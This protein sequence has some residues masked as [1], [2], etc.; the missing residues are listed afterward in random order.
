MSFALDCGPEEPPLE[1]TLCTHQSK[2]EFDGQSRLLTYLQDNCP[3]WQQDP[4]NRYTVNYVLAMLFSVIKHHGF[5]DRKMIYHVRGDS[6]LFR[7]LG[8]N[9][10]F[11]PEAR[12]LVK[13]HLRCNEHVLS[14]E[15]SVPFHCVPHS[16]ETII[17][18][19][20]DQVD[21]NRLFL[22]ICYQSEEA[23]T[24]HINYLLENWSKYYY[25]Y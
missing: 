7:A 13:T 25:V 18:L 20:S 6:S 10:F 9:S 5:F 17:K 14:N 8:R 11:I 22:D 3:A 23:T 4:R 24:R 16:K 19:F 2:Y 12:S 21:S 15:D 1:Y